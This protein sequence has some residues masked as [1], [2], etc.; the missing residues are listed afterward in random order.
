MQADQ[1]KSIR[2]EAVEAGRSPDAVKV[3]TSFDCVVAPTRA[4]AVATHEAIL[5]AQNPGR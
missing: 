5:A 2:A 1:S 3:M 4:E